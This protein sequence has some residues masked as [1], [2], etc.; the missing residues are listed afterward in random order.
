MI[1]KALRWLGLGAVFVLMITVGGP[2]LLFFSTPNVD[3]LIQTDPQTTALIKQ[4]E[5]VGQRV[6]WIPVPYEAISTDLKLAVVVAEDFRFFLHS[7]FD[8]YEIQ[9]ATKIAVTGKR[10]RGAS[11]IT[12]QL[13]RNLWLTQD[14]TVT[15]KLKEAMLA[16]KLER[17]LSKRRILELYLNTAIFGPE[18]LG[19]EA[20][21]QRYFNVPA[22]MITKDEAAQL[23]AS[24]PAP[25]QWYPG[26]R[27]PRAGRHYQRILDRMDKAAGLRRLL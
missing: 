27:S 3:V 23:A 16:W 9:A 1:R 22:S 26:S 18:T 2:V 13:A 6:T 20:A 7:G 8:H 21:A 11:T 15:R 5:A 14:R 19:V 17:R 12:Q 24:L 4:A 10:L 25:S